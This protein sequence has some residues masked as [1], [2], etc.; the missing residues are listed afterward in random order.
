LTSS[1]RTVPPNIFYCEKCSSPFGGKRWPSGSCV[2]SRLFPSLVQGA[3]SGRTALMCYA[4]CVSMR[5]AAH[6]GPS[7]SIPC[8]CWHCIGKRQG[9]VDRCAGGNHT[10]LQALLLPGS[11]RS[12]V[13][14]AVSAQARFLLYTPQ[15][16]MK[17]DATGHFMSHHP[18]RCLDKAPKEAELVC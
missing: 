3:T 1:H 14:R 2:Y 6:C 8:T 11:Y 10:H 16:D 17:H 4:Y 15:L 5:P 12:P 9:K 7:A 13:V 18:H